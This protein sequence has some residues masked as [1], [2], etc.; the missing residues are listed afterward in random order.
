MQHHAQGSR[1]RG[2]PGES[3]ENPG[4]NPGRTREIFAGVPGIQHQPRQNTFGQHKSQHTRR[5]KII[6]EGKYQN[7]Q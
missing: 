4:G 6:H 7:P 5:S 2:T 3:G 1:M